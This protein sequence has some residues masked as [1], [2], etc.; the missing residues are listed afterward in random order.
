MNLDLG[1]EVKII[2]SKRIVIGYD[3]SPADIFISDGK[4]VS[5]DPWGSQQ[6]AS[7][8][9][10]L[11]VG[12]LVVMPGVIDPHVHVNE[13][14][15]T[16]WEG[17]HTATLAA[18]SGGITTIVDMP[19]NSLPPTTSLSNFRTKLKAAEG[20]CFVDVAFWG[21]VIP[22]NQTE[23]IPMLHAGV[24]GFKCFLISSGV[25]EFPHVS[26]MDLHA[27]MSELQGTN[28]VL[29]FHA[30]LDLS[31][32]SPA[33]GDPVLYDTFLSSRPDEMEVA[34]IELVTDLCL[35]YQV[36]CHIV[37][38][39]SVKSIPIIRRAKKAGAP[40]TVE[41]THH[42]LS[43]SAENI[44]PGA[45]YY[46][47][48]PPVRDCANKEALWNALQQG[49]IDMVVSD[50]SPCTPDLKLLQDGDFMGAW[51]GISSLQLGLS[52]FWSSAQGRGF[53]L[54]DVSRLLSGNPAKLCNLGNCK[55]SIKVG[56]DA[57]FVIWDPDKEF[58]VQVKRLH[59]KNKINPYLGFCLQGEV[60]ATIL[61]GIL[62]YHKGRHFPKP[63]GKPVFIR[64]IN[65]PESRAPYY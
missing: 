61:R 3:V 46:K 11:D 48:C 22:D 54:P 31:D 57:D 13:P 52:L 38:L 24:A 34:A 27:A 58:Q 39:S 12:D 36:H 33:C 21:G 51:G 40:I 47:C 35:Q 18:A 56:Y 14:G 4:I 63:S 19:L 65:P 59:H 2:R 41:T 25:P 5:I 43:L 10:L 30:E 7:G 16:N 45:T 23:L 53:T 62:V 44:P 1:S 37:H 15:R 29:L 49:H 42:Y 28:S 55:G 17:F 32:G 50:H 60:V 20:Q 8:S 26:L 64:T 9:K 6:P